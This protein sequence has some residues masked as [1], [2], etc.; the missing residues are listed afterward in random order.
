MISTKSSLFRLAPILAAG[1]FPGLVNAN[2]SAPFI[3]P[4]AFSSISVRLNDQSSNGC[5]TNLIETK[6][7]LEDYLKLRGFAVVEDVAD[8]PNNPENSI[9]DLRVFSKRTQ[10]G[11]Y[12]IIYIELQTLL[13][14]NEE[15]TIRGAIGT[16][17]VYTFVN[18]QNINELVLDQVKNFAVD[19]PY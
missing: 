8:R 16:P 7:Y 5:W 11:C 12:G 1:L 13:E 19:W 2:P 9:V 17:L 3:E 14:W 6:L 18:H 4:D 15:I 10:G